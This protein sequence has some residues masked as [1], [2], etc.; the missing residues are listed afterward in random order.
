[1]KN[2]IK[3]FW[4]S[5]KNRKLVYKLFI[6]YALIYLSLYLILNSALSGLSEIAGM[7]ENL[8][9]F[10]FTYLMLY[11]SKH[12][13]I[14]LMVLSFLFFA[15]ILYFFYSQYIVK[16]FIENLS[17]SEKTLIN[18]RKVLLCWIFNLPLII[19]FLVLFGKLY[20]K[21]RDLITENPSFASILYYAFIILLPIFMIY[22]FAVLDSTR[23]IAIKENK[24]SVK[25]YFSSL[26]IGI[27]KYPLF[28][29]IYVFYG[30]FAIL[31]FY[32]YTLIT[33]F[34]AAKIWGQVLILM[35]FHFL[36][37]MAQLFIK[38]SLMGSEFYLLSKRKAQVKRTDNSE[39][40]D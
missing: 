36:Y 13:E 19:V 22:L 29:L 7:G 31:V 3:G 34:I 25:S 23:I 38:F 40:E 12:S 20:M 11:L 26:I 5:V 1:M 21:S 8:K 15:F 9:N 35:F 18:Y 14:Q 10:N 6:F 28:L 4:S 33:N 37:F 32:L 24:S 39:K 16:N 17:D 2:I 30:I 27:K